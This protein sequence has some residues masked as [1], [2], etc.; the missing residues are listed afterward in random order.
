MMTKNNSLVKS[1]V[2]RIA[3]IPLVFL[4]AVTL[5]F[6]QKTISSDSLFK[7]ENEWWLPILEKHGKEIL[8]FNNFEQIFEMGEENSINN[9][10][11]TLKNAYLIIRDSLDN[12]MIIESPLVYHDFNNEIIR[13]NS[14]TIM[15]FHKDSDPNK[16]LEKYKIEKMELFTT[17][18]R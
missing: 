16:P 18:N 9:G 14:G 15:K 11:C 10:I 4:L 17:R 1:I 12:Y 2:R 8:A 6:S 13:T 5:T 7:F 3:I